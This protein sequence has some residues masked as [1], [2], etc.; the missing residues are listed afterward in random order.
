[1]AIFLMLSSLARATDWDSA[2]A[3]NRVNTIGT[4]ILKANNNKYFLL[5]NFRKF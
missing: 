3:L 2:A 5:K 1:M 4:K